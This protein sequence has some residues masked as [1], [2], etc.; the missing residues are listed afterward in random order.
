MHPNIVV[1]KVECFLLLFIY[2]DNE[3]HTHTHTR[4][5]EQRLHISVGGVTHA[6]TYIYIKQHTCVYKLLLKVWFDQERNAAA[7]ICT[8]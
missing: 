1:Y 3:I 7:Q 6:Y 8:K 2:H 5:C 4:M